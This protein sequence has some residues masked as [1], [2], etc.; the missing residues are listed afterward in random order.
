VGGARGSTAAALNAG[1]HVAYPIGAALVAV[2]IAVA[3]SVLRPRTTVAEQ[4]KITIE[5]STATPCA[6]AA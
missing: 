4:R 1:Y 6:D 5:P 2:A 3:M